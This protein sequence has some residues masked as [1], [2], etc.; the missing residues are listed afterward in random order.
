MPSELGKLVVISF[1]VIRDHL[2]GTFP[3]HLALFSS[4]CQSLYRPQTLENS[5]GSLHTGGRWWN[6]TQ[7]L[8]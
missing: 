3:Q 8:E 4:K 7:Y 6:R 1:P 2:Q 5:I